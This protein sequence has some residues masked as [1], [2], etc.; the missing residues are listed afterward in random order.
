MQRN[1][2]TAQCLWTVGL[3]EGKNITIDSYKDLFLVRE[4]TVDPIFSDNTSVNRFVISQAI[5][6]CFYLLYDNW[7]KGSILYSINTDRFYMTNPKHT[8]P[9][10]KLKKLNSKSRISVKHIELIVS[11]YILRSIIARI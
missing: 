9:S 2:D 11:L 6:R 7:T 5:F 8:Y 10:K 4:Q 3:A 1:V